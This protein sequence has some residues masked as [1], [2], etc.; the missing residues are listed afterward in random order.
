MYKFTLSR[1]CLQ[2][3]SAGEYQVY[4]LYNCT[5]R[6]VWAASP[7]WVDRHGT[8]VPGLV[9]AIDTIEHAN[10]RFLIVRN[11]SQYRMRI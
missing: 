8:G 11:R 2:S 5:P 1:I 7:P 4:S 3:C 6:S 10:L 9:G